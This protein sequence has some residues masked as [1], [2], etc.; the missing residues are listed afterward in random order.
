MYQVMK[1]H[2]ALYALTREAQTNSHASTLST[3]QP[4]L[5]KFIDFS[6]ETKALRYGNKLVSIFL[7]KKYGVLSRI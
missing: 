5:T 4:W 1:I 6:E 7:M 3:K 2:D